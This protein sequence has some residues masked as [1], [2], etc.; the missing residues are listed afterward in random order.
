MYFAALSSHVPTKHQKKLLWLQEQYLDAQQRA[1]P[2]DSVQQWV[3]FGPGPDQLQRQRLVRRKSWR[4]QTGLAVGGKGGKGQ[5]WRVMMRHAA[6]SPVKIC[7]VVL[8]DLCWGNSWILC[9]SNCVLLQWP[10]PF[11]SIYLH[12]TLLTAQMKPKKTDKLRIVANASSL[13][14]CVCVC[15]CGHWLMQIFRRPPLKSASA[16]APSD[17]LTQCTTWKR[18]ILLGIIDLKVRVKN[19]DCEYRPCYISNPRESRLS[20]SWE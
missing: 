16:Q 8:F 4:V 13:H 5:K 6:K 18:H 10:T 14:V 7:E 19:C 11:S 17:E 1:F 2:V 9:G 3:S 15:L 12:F 20:S